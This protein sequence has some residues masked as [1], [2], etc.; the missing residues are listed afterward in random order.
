VFDVIG[1]WR[2]YFGFSLLLTI[3]GLNFILA[4][5]FSENL[6]LKFSLDYTGGT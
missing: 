4:T 6:G 5:P 1:Q 2:W 3:P